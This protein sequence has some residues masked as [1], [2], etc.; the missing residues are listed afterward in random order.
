VAIYGLKKENCPTAEIG[1][2]SQDY[3]KQLPGQGPWLFSLCFGSERKIYFVY[4]LEFSLYPSLYF[5][6]GGI[7]S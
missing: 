6:L 1:S 3:N 2:E 7:Q 5:F 4:C